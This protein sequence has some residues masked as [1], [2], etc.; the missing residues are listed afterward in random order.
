M[1]IEIARSIVAGVAALGVTGL[2]HIGS[3]A[4][5]TSV[6][7]RVRA[8]AEALA[9]AASKEFNLFLQKQRVAQADSSKAPP[10]KA[11]RPDDASGPM[12]WFGSSGR[13]F[14]NLMRMLAGERTPVHPWDPVSEAAKRADGRGTA[15][16]T[17]ET[18]RV[19]THATAPPQA[20]PPAKQAG[21]DR[22]IAEATNPKPPVKAARARSSAAAKA[23]EAPV[24]TLEK[25]QPAST[26]TAAQPKAPA[27]TA[28]PPGSKVASATQPAPGA[29]KKLQAA[30]SKA[31]AA[32]PPASQPAAAAETKPAAAAKE[33]AAQPPPTAQKSAAAPPP[34][35][36]TPARRRAPRA[37][38]PTSRR[39]ARAACKGAGR[40]IAGAGWYTAREGDSLW[41]IAETHFGTGMAYRRIQAANRSTIGDPDYI[42]PCQRIYIPRRRTR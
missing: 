18:G 10:A 28:P 5:A 8:E 41:R 4:A 12:G 2:A 13:E 21:E 17:A 27:T 31:V 36:A 11:D 16:R 25:Q 40:R 15:A 20:S 22:K 9:E 30:A 3:S 14:Q 24:K 32:P 19:A 26:K 33:A 38:R 37:A 1:R 42:W 35:A 6:E 39:A 7:E 34:A 29:A 23:G